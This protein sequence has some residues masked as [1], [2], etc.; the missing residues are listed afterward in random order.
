MVN[1]AWTF[2][3]QED[4][5]CHITVDTQY[6]TDRVMEALIEAPNNDY[7]ARRVVELL[8]DNAQKDARIKLLAETIALISAGEVRTVSEDQFAMLV[9]EQY[10]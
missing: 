3:W 1:S 10:Q 8:D 6:A 9:G 7:L 5:R 4:G 2:D